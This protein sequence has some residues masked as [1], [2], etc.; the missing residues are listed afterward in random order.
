[1]FGN[2]SDHF[3]PIHFQKI[4]DVISM[5]ALWEVHFII[6]FSVFENPSKCSLRVSPN[7]ATTAGD[8]YMDK[9]KEET[10]DERGDELRL[11]AIHG[12]VTCNM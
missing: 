5:I 8:R 1:M 2:V 11:A 6:V 10:P 4:D 9:V 3:S 7:F 12:D